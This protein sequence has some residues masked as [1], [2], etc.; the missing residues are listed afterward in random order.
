MEPAP[1]GC[2]GLHHGQG[3]PDHR[4]GGPHARHPRDRYGLGAVLGPLF[5]IIIADYFILRRQQVQVSELFKSQGTHSFNNGWN[6]RAVWAF[7][8]ASIPS[9][10]VAVVQVDFCKFLSP[11]SWFIGAGL[12]FLIHLAMSRNDPYIVK[13]LEQAATVDLDADRDSV[14]R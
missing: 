5:G 8:I 14:A 4:Q 3:R 1:V 11:F 7:I 2:S 12:G 13:A 6:M 9:I 10:L